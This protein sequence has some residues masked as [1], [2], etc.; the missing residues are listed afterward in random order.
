[1]L[2]DI[3]NNDLSKGGRLEEYAVDPGV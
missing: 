3:C 1:M 2:I